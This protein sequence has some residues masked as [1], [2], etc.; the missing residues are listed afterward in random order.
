MS[1]EVNVS[2]DTALRSTSPGSEDLASLSYD[3]AGE[4]C[5]DS[6]S[7]HEFIVRVFC[8]SLPDLYPGNAISV[9]MVK[10][11]TTPHYTQMLWLPPVLT[12]KLHNLHYRN[13]F[14]WNRDTSSGT[15]RAPTRV[16]AYSAP[17]CC[18]R[19]KLRKG[20]FNTHSWV[21]GHDVGCTSVNHV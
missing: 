19:F 3:A 14:R 21:L 6:E 16:L 2:V 12:R 5:P 15:C 4:D 9:Q 7:Q 11:M 8:T 18:G 17:A 1:G 20:K 10:S 13:R